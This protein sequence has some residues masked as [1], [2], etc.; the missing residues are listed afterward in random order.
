MKMSVFDKIL[1]T[2]SPL[3]VNDLSPDEKKALFALMVQYGASNGFAYDRFFQKGFQPWELDGI[4]AI[5]SDFLKAHEKEMMESEDADGTK[6]YAFA[7]SLDN[8]DGGFWR[9]IGQVPG[10]ITAFKNIMHEKGMM[11]D[12]TIIKRFNADDWK[13]Y[14]R[15]GV[16]KIISDYVQAQKGAA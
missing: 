9:A 1:Q 12:V 2:K 5:K 10:L 7:L 6:G 15:C 11:S 16:R 3:G 13:P 4:D 14:E 8:S